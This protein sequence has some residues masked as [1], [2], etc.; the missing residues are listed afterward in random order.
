MAVPEATLWH[1]L[2][3][4]CGASFGFL[5]GQGMG[6]GFTLAAT[7]IDYVIK[8]WRWSNVLALGLIGLPGAFIALPI[9]FLTAVPGMPFGFYVNSDTPE[10]RML[11]PDDGL[12]P[13][14]RRVLKVQIVGVVTLLMVSIGMARGQR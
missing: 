12:S 13:F 10:G 8:R 3:A 14:A 6:F 5:C 4:L 2:T 9:G 11:Y 1:L 7:G